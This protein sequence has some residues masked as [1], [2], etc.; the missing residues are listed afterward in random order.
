MGWLMEEAFWLSNE[1]GKG[2]KHKDIKEELSGERG[3]YEENTATG[4]D[5]KR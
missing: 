5:Q 3:Q 1:I 2:F 4:N